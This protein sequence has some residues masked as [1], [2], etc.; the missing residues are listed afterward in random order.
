MDARFSSEI[1]NFK[2]NDFFEWIGI[3]TGYGLDDGGSILRK[4]TIFLFIVS[5][6]SLLSSGYLGAIAPGGKATV[7]WSWPL[8]SN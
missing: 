8:P 5:R 4:G 2:L 6:P 1:V 3:A 7:A